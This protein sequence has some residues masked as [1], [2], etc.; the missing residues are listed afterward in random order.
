M[1]SIIFNKKFIAIGNPERG[2]SRFISLLSELG[3]E[4]NLVTDLNHIDIMRTEDKLI[5]YSQKLSLLRE[6]SISFLN[7]CL[8]Q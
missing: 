2:L 8:K 7:N 6:N 5:D 3:L 1:F 4:N